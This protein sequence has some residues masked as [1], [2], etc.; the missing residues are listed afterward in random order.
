M[1]S[2]LLLSGRWLLA[3]VL[4]ASGIPKLSPTGKNRVANAMRDYGVPER[5]ITPA[6]SVLPWLEFSSGA[7][8]CAGAALVVSASL[9]AVLMAVFAA[10]VGWH[11]ARGR[12]FACGCGSDGTRISWGIVARDLAL[13]AL[14]IAIATGPSGALAVWP[15][16]TSVR[17]TVSAATAIPVPLITILVL[18]GLRLGV[19]ARQSRAGSLSLNTAQM[20]NA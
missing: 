11:V 12:A 4:I 10:T 17:A 1:I 16:A 3:V 2:D 19:S 5:L 15:G 20:R 14:A 7:L 13:C 6:A 9:V 18:L 8:L